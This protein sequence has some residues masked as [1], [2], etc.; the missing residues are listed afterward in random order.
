MD[1]CLDA[2]FYHFILPY[3]PTIDKKIDENVNDFHVPILLGGEGFFKKDMH[4]SFKWIIDMGRA[5]KTYGKE[6]YGLNFE[7]SIEVAD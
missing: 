4:N 5:F 2:F 1:E 3:V 6:R 7:F